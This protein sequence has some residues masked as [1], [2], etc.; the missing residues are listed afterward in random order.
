MKEVYANGHEIAAQA[1]GGKVTAAF[2]DVCLSPP[3]PPAGPIPVPYPNSSFSKDM[4]NGSKSVMIGGKPVMLRDQS[5]YATS[6]LGDE[7]ATRNF[8]AGVITHTITGKTYFNSWSMDV[9]FEGKNVPR[10]VDLTTSNHGSNS[11]ESVP[12]P[13][14]S[15]SSAASG[16]QATRDACPCCAGPLH[17]NQKN[18]ET[19]EPYDTIPE[20]DFYQ[21]IAGHYMKRRSEMQKLLNEL[22]ASNKP[23]PGWAT[24]LASNDKNPAY[25]SLTKS[26]VIIAKGGRL[27][28]GL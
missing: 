24:E 5:Y 3:A 28:G 1:G 27:R 10:H 14:L 4:K 13:N 15:Q 6:P 26:D 21:G 18:P 22:A 9:Q 23:L 8:G 12:I 7:A 16:G 19:G 20:A 17:E 2:P 11:N 25:R